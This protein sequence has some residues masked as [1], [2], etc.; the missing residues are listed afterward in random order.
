MTMTNENEWSY[1][2]ISDRDDRT[3]SNDAD[4]AEQSD[5]DLDDLN[6]KHPRSCRGVVASGI[7]VKGFAPQ[8]GEQEA[9]RG[10]TQSQ[11]ARLGTELTTPMPCC[12]TVGKLFVSEPYHLDL[13]EL[14]DLLGVA[15]EGIVRA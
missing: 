1:G 8:M 15:R 13:E 7:V 10:P 5:D 9:H 6:D 12:M 4:P 11:A 2:G 3:V 14:K